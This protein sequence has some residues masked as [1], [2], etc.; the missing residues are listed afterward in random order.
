MEREQVHTVKNGAANKNEQTEKQHAGEEDI[1][2]GYMGNARYYLKKAKE[3]H[4]KTPTDDGELVSAKPFVYYNLND[5]IKQY[6]LT[7]RF[8]YRREKH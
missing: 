3:V 8:Y 4:Q 5:S 1:A 7:L 6:H 2:E